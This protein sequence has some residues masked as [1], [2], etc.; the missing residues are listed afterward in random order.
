MPKNAVSSY[1]KKYNEVQ[2]YISITYKTSCIDA[3]VGFFLFCMARF[4]E[5]STR[6]T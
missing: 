4:L 2:P 5:T 1:S 3:F 6:K